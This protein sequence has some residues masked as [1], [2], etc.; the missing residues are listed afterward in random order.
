MKALVLVA[1]TSLVLGVLAGKPGDLALGGRTRSVATDTTICLPDN[2]DTRRAVVKF[3][4]SSAFA[5]DRTDLGLSVADTATLRVLIDSTDA[6]SSWRRCWPC[7]AA[8][9]AYCCTMTSLVVFAEARR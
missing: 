2:P 6:C 4:I 7:V 9:N 5:N 1:G 8:G 3:L